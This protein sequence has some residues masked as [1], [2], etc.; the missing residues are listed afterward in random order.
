MACTMIR[1]G[2]TH[3]APG[4]VPFSVW[5]AIDTM[6]LHYV[7]KL[8][9]RGFA[10]HDGRLWTFDRAE[11]RH[12]CSTINKVAQQSKFYS[13]ELERTFCSEV[14]TPAAPVLRAIR[15][16]EQVDSNGKEVVARYLAAQL[17]RVPAGKQR[18]RE[19][20]PGVA[21]EILGEVSSRIDSLVQEDQ[22]FEEIGQRRKAE[23][24]D[25]IERYTREPPDSIWYD[26][27]GSKYLNTISDA[28]RTMSWRFHVTQDGS[29]FLTSD[30]PV[31]FF[32]GLGLGGADSELSFPVA[33]DVV[34][35]GDRRS[36]SDLQFFEASSQLVKEVNRRTVSVA[37]RFVYARDNAAWIAPFSFKNHTKL[38][39]IR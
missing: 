19:S 7:P 30:N 25:M 26:T 29:Q 8:Y 9:L 20:F 33:H 22:R 37:S 21:G 36:T 34:M 15:E 24:D 13:D 6:G 32:G 2:V 1:R 38:N 16:K 4:K 10:N 39:S 27:L 35:C 28:I 11:R 31:F 18:Y 12:Y 14:E 23:V 17:K 3:R 5:F